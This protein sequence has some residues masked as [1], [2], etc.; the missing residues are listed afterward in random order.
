M[1]DINLLRNDVEVLKHEVF[2]LHRDQSTTAIDS[3]HVKM[4]FPNSNTLVLE[5]AAVSNLLGCPSMQVTKISSKSIKVK[6]PKSCLHKAMESSHS[7]FHLVYVWKNR[8]GRPPANRSISLPAQQPTNTVKIATWNCR[9]LHNSIPYI[10]HLTS[11]SVDILVLQEHWLWPFEL[12]ELQSI[13]SNFSYIGVCDSRLSPKSTLTQG[14]GWC[15]IMWKNSI[16]ATPTSSLKSDRICGIQ[17]S[18]ANSD[19][20]SILRVYMPSSE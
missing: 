12:N 15:A 14:C 6:I 8:D 20:L 19:P 10:N 16:P 11:S 2:R 13:D 7:S 18:I 17:I 3:C 4:F 5:P 1:K 9:G